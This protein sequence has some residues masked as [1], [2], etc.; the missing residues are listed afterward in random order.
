MPYTTQESKQNYKQKKMLCKTYHVFS[1]EARTKH[2]IHDASTIIIA[3]IVVVSTSSFYY[4]YQLQTVH[5]FIRSLFHKVLRKR[6][7]RKYLVMMM[8]MTICMNGYYEGW[9]RCTAYFMWKSLCII[10]II[11]L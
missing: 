11:L 8:M 1:K 7:Q 10:T 5:K 9:R 2:T 6:K 4:Y 3:V